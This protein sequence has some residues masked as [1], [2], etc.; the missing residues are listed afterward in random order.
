MQHVIVCAQCGRTQ[1]GTVEEAV[2]LE[3]T[4]P[5][6]HCTT[7]V[8]THG[9]QIVTRIGRIPEYLLRQLMRSSYV[10]ADKCR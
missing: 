3:L 7:I 8:N 2:N 10:D 4:C 1:F 5:K 6:C 9:D